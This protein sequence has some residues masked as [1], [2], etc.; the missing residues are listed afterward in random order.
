MQLARAKFI[1]RV[2]IGS[3]LCAMTGCGPLPPPHVLGEEQVITDFDP[4]ELD[5]GWKLFAA[6][7]F[8]SMY[9]EDNTSWKTVIDSMTW[10]IASVISGFGKSMLQSLTSDLEHFHECQKIYS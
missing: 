3:L 2:V 6:D 4:I 10:V 1:F 5:N 9:G 8:P 7:R